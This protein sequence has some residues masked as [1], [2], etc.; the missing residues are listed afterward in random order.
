LVGHAAGQGAEDSGGTEAEEEEDADRI[1]AIAG[2][3]VQGVD[4]RAHHPVGEH[5][6]QESRE[7]HAPEALQP[8]A[9]LPCSILTRTISKPAQE[10]V[11]TKADGKR[12]RH[13]RHG[14]L[15]SRLVVGGWWF[16]DQTGARLNL[17]IRAK[18][19]YSPNKKTTPIVLC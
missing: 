19:H 11:R 1:H 6:R 7:V 2:G 12:G 15:P 17:C 4:V 3:H 13:D 18:K 10:E 8:W 14:Y 5:G 16:S 9:L